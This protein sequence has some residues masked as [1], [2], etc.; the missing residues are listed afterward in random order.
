[1]LYTTFFSLALFSGSLAVP[2]QSLKTRQTP[3]AKEL[4]GGKEAQR[5]NRFFASNSINATAVC[6]MSPLLD[7]SDDL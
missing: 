7:R 2:L 1:M 5:L 3:S 6:G 4:A